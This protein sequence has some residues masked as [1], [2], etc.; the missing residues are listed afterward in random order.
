MN[1][2]RPASML[3]AV[4]LGFVAGF[5]LAWYLFSSPSPQPI[6]TA[7]NADTAPAHAASA[8]LGGFPS[9]WS[10][11]ASAHLSTP[12]NATV[13]EIW[14]AGKSARNSFEASTE[15]QEKLRTAA[16]AD[17]AAL[18]SLIQRFDAER[19]PK[20]REMLKSVLSSIPSAE[21]IALSSRLAV[22]GSAVQR[23]DGFE[24]LKQISSNSPEVRNL[25]RHALATEQSPAVLSQAVSALTP[26]VVAGPEAEAI[27][28]QLNQLS[29]HQ[30]P[31]V[32]SQSILQL[33]QWDKTGNTEGRLNSSLADPSP[34]VRQ[35]AVAAIAE[36]GSRSE[37]TKNALMQVIRNASES[38]QVKDGALY[39]LQRFSLS[40]AEHDLY[41]QVRA[42]IDQQAK[43]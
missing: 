20:A 37:D 10:G 12:K 15:I 32:R 41:V 22:S 3:A 21:V 40:K 26:T 4:G 8:G 18:R 14:A 34:E 24:M 30:D 19:D 31:S 6:G 38:M 2:S 16:K 7:A 1:R 28:A 43:E 39:A 9:I 17:P 23:E 5:S 33:A 25:V 36:T 42:Q 11:G 27:V 35:A 13:E 29:L